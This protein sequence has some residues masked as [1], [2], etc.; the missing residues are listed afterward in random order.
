[1][2][3]KT[4]I[5]CAVVVLLGLGALFLFVE[6][7]NGVQYKT[8]PVTSGS[9]RATVTATGTVNPVV[10]VNV[11]TQ[12]SG[13]I[14]HIYADYNSAVN[15]GQVIAQIDPAIFN[16]QADQARANLMAAQANVLKAKA[17]LADSKRTFER[18]RQLIA[19]GLIAQSDFDTSETTWQANDAQ[20]KAAEAQVSQTQAALDFTETNLR[21][22]KILSPVD[23][24]VVSRNVDVGQTVA[25]SFQTPTLF[26]IAQDLTKMQIDTSVDEADIGKIKVGQEVDFNVDAYPDTLFKGAVWQVR[27]SPTT[28]QNVVTYDVVVQVENKEYK[29]KPGMTANVSIV[30]ADRHSVLRVPNAVLRFKPDEQESKTRGTARQGGQALWILEAGKPKRVRITTGISDGSNTEIVSGELKEGQEV[31]VE[32]LSKAKKA[33]GNA[34]PFTPMRPPR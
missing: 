20:V 17:A 15:K 31:V 25:A 13:T 27:I 3:R 22:T 5:G 11:G 12:V 16:A 30:T 18:N 10:T 34:S 26:Y 1:M 29:L 24:I 6:K 2:I 32:S 7:S 19:K 9:I 33:G 23:G 8:V 14:K 21:Y 4:L 28:V